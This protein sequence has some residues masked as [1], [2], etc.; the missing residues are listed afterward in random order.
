MLSFEHA[1]ALSLRL[2]TQA[3]AT[4]QM[5]LRGMTREGAFTLQHTTDSGG[6]ATSSTFRIPDFPILLS[7]IDTDLNFVQG[8]CYARLELLINGDSLYELL[9]GYVSFQ[10]SLSWPVNFATEVLPGR[11]N[12]RQAIGANP[13]PGSEVSDTP[14]TSRTWRILAANVTLVTSATVANRRVHLNFIGASAGNIDCFGALDQAA[15][16]TVRYCFAPYGVIPDELDSGVVLIHLP[17]DIY[18]SSDGAIQTVTTNLQVGDNFGAAE[19][20][21]EEYYHSPV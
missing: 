17:P 18:I 20:M 4:G 5:T 16:S 11:A 19:Y 15:S 14:G 2:T 8:A 12:I 7:I 21:V 6:S 13:S 10:K 3:N 1:Q 9:D